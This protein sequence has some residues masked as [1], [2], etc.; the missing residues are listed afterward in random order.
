MSQDTPSKGFEDRQG[1]ADLERDTDSKSVDG[2]GSASDSSPHDIATKGPT[3]EERK[4]GAERIEALYAVFGEKNGAS[5]WLL[6]LS[7]ALFFYAYSLASNTVSNYLAFATSAFGEHT[8]LSTISAMVYIIGAVGEFAL[9]IH[10][11][12][13]FAD[14]VWRYFFLACGVNRK[15]IR[16]TTR[17]YHL[18]SDR[19]RFLSRPLYSRVHRRCRRPKRSCTR[20]RSVFILS[21]LYLS[22]LAERIAMALTLCLFV[23]IGELLYAIGG[24]GLT[25][26]TSLIVADLSPLQWRGF[27]TALPDMPYIINAYVS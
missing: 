13:I 23:C 3:A 9:S 25:L 20:R 4:S 5:I 19:L 2:N 21:L 17:R 26:V 24:V 16:G 7:L 18:S 10:S 12:S 6:Y 22:L 8:V 15:T 14:C 1:R 27:I 11:T